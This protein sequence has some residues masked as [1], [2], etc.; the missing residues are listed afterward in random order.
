MWL[1]QYGVRTSYQASPRERN[2]DFGAATVAETVEL[3]SRLLCIGRR[4]AGKETSSK[5]PN[6]FEVHFC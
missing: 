3:T 5:K 4:W 2:E 6:I 1:V